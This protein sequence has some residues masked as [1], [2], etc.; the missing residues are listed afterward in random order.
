[1]AKPELTKRH[2][3]NIDKATTEKE[4]ARHSKKYYSTMF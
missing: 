2:R 4:K 3:K 1:M